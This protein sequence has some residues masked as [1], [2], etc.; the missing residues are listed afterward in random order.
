MSSPDQPIEAILVDYPNRR[1]RISRFLVKGSFLVLVS[2]CGLAF[3]ADALSSVIP[4]KQSNQS[5]TPPVEEKL[6]CSSKTQ[7]IVTHH[8]TWQSVDEQLG[9]PD[10]TIFT[11]GPPIGSHGIVYDDINDYI[12]NLNRGYGPSDLPDNVHLKVPV[13]ATCGY[14]LVPIPQS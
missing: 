5:D 11:G 10:N 13:L 6:V 12:I 2:A 4:Y 7:E 8:S 1:E 14:R 3:C 9:A